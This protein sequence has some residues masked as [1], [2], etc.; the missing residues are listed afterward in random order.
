MVETAA[1]PTKTQAQVDQAVQD[2]KSVKEGK[3]PNAPKP[4]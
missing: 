4:D 2:A 3:D 1:D